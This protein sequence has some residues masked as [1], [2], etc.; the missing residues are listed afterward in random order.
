LPGH[1]GA[2]ITLIHNACIKTGEGE[3]GRRVAAQGDFID[4]L[5]GR[6]KE[7][8]PTIFGRWSNGYAMERLTPA[9]RRPIST[10][11][12]VNTLR[13][14]VWPQP[15]RVAVDWEAHK[16]Y[17][18]FRLLELNDD[19]VPSRLKVLEW[20]A[21]S[22]ATVRELDLTPCLTHGDPT[23]DNVMCRAC[24][25]RY[26]EPVLIDPIPAR[27]E[28]PDLLAVDLG[29]IL[30]SVYGYELI[31]EGIA[32]RQYTYEGCPEAFESVSTQHDRMAAHY[33]MAF[34]FLRLLPYMPDKLKPVMGRRLANLLG[35]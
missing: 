4:S 20:F 5:A 1:S 24:G 8:F 14:S 17:L 30:Q 3:V 2:E 34:H 22:L 31:L 16:D 10:A 13:L 25:G 11:T 18:F 32:P 27:P 33:F 19:I 7:S 12:I 9:G 6:A 26:R 29:K 28:V 23:R 21:K 15:A 35:V